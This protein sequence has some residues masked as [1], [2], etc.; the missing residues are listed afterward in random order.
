MGARQD[1]P[2][3]DRTRRPSCL[4][5]PRAADTPQAPPLLTAGGPPHPAPAA[6]EL[7]GRRT[8]RRCEAARAARND[9]ESL[10]AARAAAAPPQR[11]AGQP[12]NAAG[13]RNRDYVI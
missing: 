3:R 13:S 9:R 7:E 2:D 5:V 11:L 4:H 8:V 10:K 6:R 1:V 12:S